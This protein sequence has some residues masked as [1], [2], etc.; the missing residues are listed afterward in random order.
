MRRAPGLAGLGAVV[1]CLTAGAVAATRGWS[2]DAGTRGSVSLHLALFLA[3]GAVWALTLALLPRLAR[4]PGDLRLIWVLALALRIPAWLGMPAHSDDVY[5]YAWDGRVTRAGINPYR[6]PP[7]APELDGLREGVRYQERGA[8]RAPPRASTR[9]PLWARINNPDLPTIYPPAAQL[10]FVLAAALPLG[11][12]GGLKCVLGACDLGVLAVLIGLLR[13]RGE[14]PRWALAWGWSPLVAVELGQ[15][16][17]LDALPLLALIGALWA[18]EVGRKGLAGVLLGLATAAKLITAPLLVAFRSGRAWG[19]MVGVMALL[20]LPFVGA[21]L[22]IAGSTGEFARRWRTNDGVYGLVQAGAERAICPLQLAIAA[23]IADPPPP[24]PSP[25]DPP[26]SPE[27]IQARCSEPLYMKK[28][29]EV[30]HAITGRSH[31]TTVFPDELAAFVARGVAGAAI[32]LVVLIVRV[33]RLAPLAGTEW[34]LGAL[35]LLTPAL[36]PWYV[37]WLVP[38]VALRRRAAWVALAML[39]PL[40]Y[41]PLGAWL[42]GEPWRDPWWTRLLEHG[43]SWGLLVWEGWRAWRRRGAAQAEMEGARAAILLPKRQGDIQ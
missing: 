12:L 37:V 8:E 4:R 24:P 36:H 20:A 23:R 41:V 6:Y 26:L 25:T 16:V 32:G 2:A 30:A 17:H 7:A 33:W 10:A 34:I 39:V 43:V 31:R 14:D 19:A 18:W 40:G 22:A 28:Y 1:A 9:G 11:P 15:N 42:S 5:R 38:L 21:R 35:L 29:P 3:A 27:E 13:R